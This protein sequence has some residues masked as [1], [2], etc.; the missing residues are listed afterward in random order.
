MPAIGIL[1]NRGFI[2]EFEDSLF[3]T[4]NQYAGT[5]AER[6]QA[7]QK[8][9]D[10]PDSK[11]ILFARGGYGSVRILDDL[12]FTAFRKHPKWL[13]GYSDITVFHMHLHQ[14]LGTE[15][16]HATMPINFTTNTDEAVHSLC[17][18]LQK[19]PL[20]T[21]FDAHPLN[22]AGSCNGQLCGGNLSVLYSLMGSKSF[23]D[24]DGKILFLEDL[25]EYLYHIDRMMQA[26]KR[27]GALNNLKALLIGAISDMNDNEIPFG[28]SAY[29][30]ISDA[31][32]AYDYPVYF[33][34]PAGHIPDN[35]ALVMGAQTEIKAA[36][37]GYVLS[38]GKTDII[39]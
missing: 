6:T 34:F 5:D 2:C 31:V 21:F 9:L 37:E 26:L 29:E 19:K 32:S 15:S 13:V 33:G 4:D 35:R 17:K 39:Y 3:N 16:I 14:V 23:P 22:R 30:I 36:D 7:M 24:T 1:E 10:N 20:N 28:K 11:A 25:D 18:A 27:S 12:D 38:Q 8:A